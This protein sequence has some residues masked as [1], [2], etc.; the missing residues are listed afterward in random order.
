MFGHPL[1]MPIPDIDRTDYFLILGA[2]P[3]ASNGSLMTAPDII[4]RL[5]NIKKRDG[6]IVLIDPRR[7]ETARVAS[8]HFFIRP[9]GDVFLLLAIVH[10]LF[11]ENLVNL[12]RLEEFYRRRGNSARNFEQILRLQRSKI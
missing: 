5:E 2:N 12:E 6:K 8:E 1:L 7:T 9:S 10:T 11:A 3:L 4:N